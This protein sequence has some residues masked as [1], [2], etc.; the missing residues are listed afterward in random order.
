MT[1][2]RT[3]ALLRTIAGVATGQSL[4]ITVWSPAIRLRT[5][6]ASWITYVFMQRMS[7]GV[8]RAGLSRSFSPPR[9]LTVSAL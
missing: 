9:D 8:R 1:L 4:S 5:L 7:S 3:S 6:R 2:Q